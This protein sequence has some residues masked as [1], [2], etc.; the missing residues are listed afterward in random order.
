MKMRKMERFFLE[1]AKYRSGEMQRVVSM[2]EKEGFSKNVID[3]FKK[4][5]IHPH[6]KGDKN[7]KKHIGMMKVKGFYS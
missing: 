1:K 5:E 3:E 7:L 4:L 2:A 6:F